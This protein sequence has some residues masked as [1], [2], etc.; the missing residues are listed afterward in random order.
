M[1]QGGE[2]NYSD[3][4]IITNQDKLS[5]EV[6][7]KPTTTDLI[8]HNTSRHPYEHSSHKLSTHPNGTT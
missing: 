2:G 4:T 6:Y 1:E 8:L 7:R 5:F 3:L